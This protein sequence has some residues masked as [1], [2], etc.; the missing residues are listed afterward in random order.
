VRGYGV[1]TMITNWISKVKTDLTRL[2]QKSSVRKELYQYDGS[3]NIPDWVYEAIKVTIPRWL[4]D[5]RVKDE[6][7]GHFPY[8][9]KGC[10]EPY[11]F[12]ASCYAA[13]V[14]K[15]LGLM[16]QLTEKQ[17]LEWIGYLQSFQDPK[18]GKVICPEPWAHDSTT[19]EDNSDSLLRVR[20]QNTIR[21]LNQTLR[22]DFGVEPP[23][24]IVEPSM[25]SLL[26]WKAFRERIDN[27]PWQ[28]NPWTAGARSMH[29]LGYMLLN[30]MAGDD[31][32][33]KPILKGLEHIFTKQDPDT[34]LFGSDSLPLYVRLNGVFKV[35]FY[36]YPIFGL[37]IPYPEKVIDSVLLAYSE[38][39]FVDGGCNDYD[40]LL[41]LDMALCFTKHRRKEAKALA[42]SRLITLKSFLQR[43]GAFSEHSHSCIT[44]IWG[45]EIIDRPRRQ[46][47][48][49][50]TYTTVSALK[51]ILS[52]LE[53][54][55]EM[56]IYNNWD[57]G[58]RSPF[59]ESCWGRT[60]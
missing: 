30:L 6:P 39:E 38:P 29:L 56:G 2:F 31:R 25:E 22:R 27:Y 33:R 55:D 34:G 54:S 40:A 26:D 57:Y 24:L 46:S 49:H 28:E 10:L 59:K 32:Y 1:T 36:M 42:I 47:D 5:I 15:T 53:L 21:W 44:H 58:Y 45:K 48:L 17:R 13:T 11:D 7:Y 9:L 16:E 18:T 23:V 52:I 3:I 20:K 4:E 43:D 37:P 51:H 14:Y 60:I 19:I 35:Y 50:G 12:F 8:A 41:L